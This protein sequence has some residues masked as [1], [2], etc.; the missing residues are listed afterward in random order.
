MRVKPGVERC[1]LL[2]PMKRS[3]GQ[4]KKQDAEGRTRTG[5]LHRAAVRRQTR[6]PGPPE[7]ARAV[8]RR[9]SAGARRAGVGW[10]WCTP[11]GSPS[12]GAQQGASS[13]RS[14]GFRAEHLAGAP[15]VH[16]E[17]TPSVNSFATNIIGVAAMSPLRGCESPRFCRSHACLPFGAGPCTVPPGGIPLLCVISDR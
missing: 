3:N 6:G 15:S 2:Y 11:P 9:A 4:W 13:A 1:A 14:L 8:E 5:I 10:L 12:Y 17:C 7:P 16:G